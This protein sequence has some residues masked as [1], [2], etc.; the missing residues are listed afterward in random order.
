MDDTSRVVILSRAKDLPLEAPTDA[1]HKEARYQ[2]IEHDGRKRIQHGVSGQLAVAAP[3][4]A[5]QLVLPDRKS[6]R[7]E[8]RTGV[9]QLLPRS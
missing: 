4:A 6:R 5:R 1:A 7:V 2:G 8:G 9:D 3:P